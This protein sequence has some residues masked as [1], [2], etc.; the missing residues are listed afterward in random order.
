MEAASPLPELAALV[1]TPVARI[2][3]DRAEGFVAKEAYPLERG[4]KL[5]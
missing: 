5:I 4:M 1:N 2:Y 3:L